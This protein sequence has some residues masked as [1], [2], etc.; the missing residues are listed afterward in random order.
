MGHTAFSNRGGAFDVALDLGENRVSVL[1]IDDD[2]VTAE[3]IDVAL[4]ALH[5]NCELISDGR[6]ALERLE[7]D[8]VDLVVLDVRLP[9]VSGMEVLQALR[10][11]PTWMTVPVIVVTA[12]DVEDIVVAALYADA[13]DVLPKP[14]NIAELRARAARRL[15]SSGQL[16]ASALVG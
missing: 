3:L 2:P 10:R 7:G 11:D 14:L 4:E 5:A 9:R 1:V 16:M 8:R 6:S 12:C 13:D 15:R